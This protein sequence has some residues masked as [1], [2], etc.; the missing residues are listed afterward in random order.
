M[1]HYQYRH[2]G[3]EYKKRFSVDRSNR[4]Y[5]YYESV[6][7][8]MRG[9]VGESGFTY[10]TL[11]GER[12]MIQSVENS[13]G[14]N[15]FVQGLLFGANELNV[16]P[17][18]YIGKMDR[19]PSSKDAASDVLP[20]GRLPEIGRLVEDFSIT[21]NLK[22]I[23]GKLVDALLYGKPDERVI[24]IAE[25][26]ENAENYIKALGLIFPAIYM[27]GVGFSVGCTRLPS[28]KITVT[29]D[30]GDAVTV[31]VKIV[32]PDTVG[33]DYDA[34]ESSGYVFDTREM[35]DN[36]DGKRSAFG[37]VVDELDLGSSA[38]VG[39]FGNR[40]KRAFG[41]DGGVDLELLER[42]SILYSFEI[43]PDDFDLACKI[44]NMKY[45]DAEQD[46]AFIDAANAVF[47]RAATNG[48]AAEDIA[49]ARRAMSYSETIRYAVRDKFCDY[50]IDNL[51]TLGSAERGML[52]E[53]LAEDSD[54][55][56]LD[57][58]I[59]KC[60]VGNIESIKAAFALIGEIIGK[61]LGH[62]GDLSGC[63]ELVR[64]AIDISDVTVMRRAG[65]DAVNAFFDIVSSYYDSLLGKCLIATLMA[66]AYSARSIDEC[67]EFRFRG[68]KQMLQNKR[69]SAREEL[70]FVNAVGEILVE[71]S[72]TFPKLSLNSD[73]DSTF[74]YNVHSGENWLN[75]R[76]NGL[77]MQDALELEVEMS[78]SGYGFSRLL[79]DLR[80]KLL[81]LDYVKENVKSGQDEMIEEYSSFF[82]RLPTNKRN[83]SVAVN[84]YLG[85][86]TGEKKISAE[87]VKYRT[88]FT[89]G[90]FCTISAAEQKRILPGRSAYE[91]FYGDDLRARKTVVD[92][93]VKTFGA[94][95]NTKA[96]AK[97]A[98]KKAKLVLLFAALFGLASL[99]CLFLPPVVISASVGGFVD[100][101]L[102]YFEPWYALVPV[103]T[104]A[105]CIASYKLSKKGDRTMAAVKMTALFG[106]LP[107]VVYVLSYI[108]FYFVRVGLFF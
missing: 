51:L 58:L 96:A 40:M 104:F 56:K 93:T 10:A 88:D 94:P 76:V 105:V 38:A 50:L 66:S 30:N 27:N 28:R 73:L 57:E 87:F 67:C 3:N 89:Y 97:P 99:L 71:L 52:V 98:R 53:M 17:A 37:E 33:L 84:S 35:R 90:Y 26:R 49:A 65:R 4:S 64:R 75:E 83:L 19:Q 95:A 15:Q 21:R 81:D 13:E 24:I 107:V 102:L 55:I 68:L 41:R 1:I 62:S 59:A 18:K 92:E 32:L 22:H 100:R 54:C 45:V 103:Y 8:K 72:R 7:E 101:L 5:D 91:A 36:Y 61:S 46:V 2:E 106:L 39:A 48:V 14:S 11:G 23:F 12:V 70:A 6:F 77:S 86:L 74:I 78:G 31:G 63:A 9:V 29:N 60:G 25:S 79:D 43:H 34:C 80:A 44:L 47:D 42:L 108:L 20:S 85:Q 82:Y 69:L 16:A